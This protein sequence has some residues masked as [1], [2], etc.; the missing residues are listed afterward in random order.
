MYLLVLKNVAH[1]VETGVKLYTAR[2]KIYVRFYM[3]LYIPLFASNYIM[4]E[5]VVLFI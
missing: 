2:L 1:L 5:E 4:L 3:L